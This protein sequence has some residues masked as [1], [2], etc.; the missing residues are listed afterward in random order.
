[1][2][3]DQRLME[4]RQ[5]TIK[6]LQMRDTGDLTGDGT[7]LEGIAVPFNTRY[8][9]F[10]DYAEVIDAD[11]DFGSRDVKISDSHGQLIGKVTS[12]T[13]Q[14]DG[15]HIT[16]KLSNTRA[17][18]EAVSLIRDGVYDAF[19]IGFNP[20]ENIIVDSD[21]GVME[22]H[23]KAVDLYE[24]A[25][26]G[27]PA[28]PQAHIT[29]QRSNRPQSTNEPK[30][31][32]MDK[33]LEEAIAGIKDE[34]R[35]MKTALAKGL[36][37]APVKT[38]GSEYRSQADY[39]QALAKGDQ[40][41]IDLMNQTR[42]LISTGDTGN[43]VA[44]IAD[45]LRLIE[46]RRKLMN[47]LTHDALPD[48]GMSMEYNVVTE[49]TTAVAKQASE[50][51]ALTFGKVKFGTKTADIETYGGYTQL[52]RQVVERSTTPMLNTALKA[53]RNAYAKA[54]ELK[55][56]TYTYDLI[57]AQRDAAENANNITVSKTLTAM[58]PDD[59]AGLLLDA[60]EIMD[61]RNA[62]MS[63]LIVSKDVA[64]ALV[65]L[66]DTGN[67]FLDLSGKGSDTLGSFDLTA[68]VGDLLRVPVQLLPGAPDGTASL[69]DPEAITVWESGGPT[70]LTNTDPTKI[71]DNYSVYGYMAIAGTFVQGLLPVKFTA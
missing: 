45:D 30:D 63:K 21:D 68:T 22:V 1:M 69:F 5:L 10:S 52:S 71:V 18:Q 53:L 39:L 51:D 31:T 58:T 11:C 55:A 13:I 28:Y 59:W 23:R 3:E 33:E 64:K 61:E 49:D 42:D 20:V 47:I 32:R 37:P 36:N 38:L 54:T 15:L 62:A 4:A 14:D 17:A 43:T 6:G 48:K 12:R 66:K 34:Q 26:T 16:A 60:A 67:R 40:A 8:K 19:S 29:S 56:R 41:A 25:V 65:A 24:V 9:L 27:I 2:S 50:G 46:Q 70:Q 35:S 7:E 44:W 57:A